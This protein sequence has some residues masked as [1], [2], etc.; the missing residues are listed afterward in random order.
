MN[1]RT[2]TEQQCRDCGQWLLFDQFYRH[3]SGGLRGSCKKCWNVASRRHQKANPEKYREYGRTQ[4]A[5]MS[6]RERSLREKFGLTQ[7]DF[8]KVLLEQNGVC[9]ICHGES[10]DS[11]LHVDHCHDTGVFRGIL[12]GLCNRMLGQG[13]DNPERLMAGAAYLWT[14]EMKMTA[15]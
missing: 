14:F 5:K 13:K 9:A 12:C 8:D 4:R 1:P 15:C 3:S 6:R 10:G 11:I 2:A 7:A